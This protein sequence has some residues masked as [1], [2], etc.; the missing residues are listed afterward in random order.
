MEHVAAPGDS[1]GPIPVLAKIRDHERKAVLGL[2]PSGPEVGNNL[3]LAGRR[4]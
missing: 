1:L 2:D 3:V 4:A